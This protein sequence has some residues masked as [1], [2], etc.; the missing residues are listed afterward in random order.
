MD[1][2]Q[3]FISYRRDGGEFLAGRVSDK[4]TDMG[5]SVFYDIESMR[6]G[7]FNN[8]IYSAIEQ[9]EDV[10]LVLPPNALDRCTDENDWV[11]KE[12]EYALKNNK[13]IIPLIM[14][15]FSF[16]PDLPECIKDVAMC[17]G[18]LVDSY[19]FDAV[20][21]RVCT[22]IKS[23]PCKAAEKESED[24]KNGVRFLDRRMF[25]QAFTCFEREISNNMSDPEPYFYGAV[26]KL[27][28]KRPFLVSRSLIN[29]I[30]KY[31]ESAIAY[32]ARGLYYYFYAYIKYDYYE[33]KLLKTV[34]SFRELL[35]T[36]ESYG[37]SEEE[38]IM[39]FELMGIPKPGGF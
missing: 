11:R 29:E 25:A 12:I 28:G 39:L 24:L 2:F 31:I 15:D 19:Y 21:S 34:P 38:K 37:I 16:P 32:G 5:Y 13:N 23:V 22:L 4:L 6:S 8:Q 36:A 18:V 10:L 20:I 30:E 17:E 14:R 7:L 27:E 26:A 35:L 1:D 3:I 33:K 9:C